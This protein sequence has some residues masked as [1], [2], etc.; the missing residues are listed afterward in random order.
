[1]PLCD[2]TTWVSAVLYIDH[3]L[4]LNP[5]LHITPHNAHRILLT[6]FNL[7]LKFNEERTY[8]NAF[9]ARVGGISALELT[10][11]E[12]CFLS[13]IGWELHIDCGLWY[14]TANSLYH[15]ACGENLICM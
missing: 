12:L 11:M 5:T 15:Y 14:R 13:L 6:A 9:L 8:S 10:H 1:M 7:A 4:E 3:V 2:H